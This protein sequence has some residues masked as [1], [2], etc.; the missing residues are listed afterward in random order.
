MLVSLLTYNA[1]TLKGHTF[2][3]GFFFGSNIFR[4]VIMTL[5]LLRPERLNASQS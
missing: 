1:I 4:C 3:S 2:P 5:T